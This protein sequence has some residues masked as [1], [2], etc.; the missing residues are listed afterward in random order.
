MCQH[1]Y[2]YHVACRKFWNWELWVPLG[3]LFKIGCSRSLEFPCEFRISSLSLAKKSVRCDRLNVYISLGTIAILTL[4]RLLIKEHFPCA[5]LFFKFFHQCLWY[6]EC[7]FCISFI[8]M[9]IFLFP[10]MLLQMEL[11]SQI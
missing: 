6:S 9:F 11:L 2:L 4:L 1:H 3:F 10:L 7:E 5:L 8:N